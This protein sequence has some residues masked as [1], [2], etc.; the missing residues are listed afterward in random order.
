MD[1]PRNADLAA[2]GETWTERTA[3]GRTTAIVASKLQPPP[4]PNLYRERPRLSARLDAALLDA[5]R[6]TLVSAAPGYGKSVAVAGWLASRKLA[7]AWLGLERQESDLARFVRYLVAAL[8][9]VRPAAGSG[10]LDLIA[11]GANPGVEEL[12]AAILQ[13]ISTSDEPFVLVLDDY[14]AIDSE[15]VHG[16]VGFLIGHWPPFVHTI[17]ITRRDPPLPLARLRAHAR[18]LELGAVDLRYTT[19]EAAL[20]VTDSMA[21]K[22]DAARLAALVERT[23]GWIAALHLS[24]VSLDERPL[25]ARFDT[26]SGTRAELFDYLADEVMTGLTAELREFLIRTS[27]ADRLTPELCD[28]LTGRHDGASLLARATRSNLLLTPADAAGESFR[29]HPLFADYLRSHLTELERREL[30]DRMADYLERHGQPEAAI[31]HALAAHSTERAI[32][33]LELQAR[34]TFEA[35]ELTTLLTW[36]DALPPERVTAS[37]ELASLRAW[38]LMFMGRLA[39]AIGE[40]QDHVSTADTVAGGP[41]EGRL[42]AL[43]SLVAAVAG[44]APVAPG[45]SALE[46]GHRALAL[47]DGDDFF[48][49][50]TL[51]SLGMATWTGGDPRAGFELWREA[52]AAAIRSGQ[53][54]AVL[55]ATAALAG[56]LNDLGRRQE[57]EALCRRTL[58]DFADHR[59]RPRPIAWLVRMSLGLVLYEANH[60]EEARFELERGFEAAS[61]YGF[62]GAMVVWAVEYVALVRQATGEPGAALQ[63]I[64]GTA[65]GARSAG[66]ALPSQTGEIEARIRLMQGD[67]VAAARW[68]DHAVLDVPAGSPMVGQMRADQ[69]VAIARVRLAQNRPGEALAL[70]EPAA[71]RAEGLG[72]LADLV[73]ILVLEARAHQALGDRPA[74]TGALARAVSIAAAGDYIRR[75]VD[76]GDQLTPL[77]AAARPASPDFVDRLHVAFAAAGRPAE[78]HREVLSE[79]VLDALTSRELEVLR[80]MA[81]GASDAEVAASLYISLATAKW[82]AANVRS[83]L[84]ASSRTRAIVRAKELG[85][86]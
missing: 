52:Y 34:P 3:T 1:A 18:L 71:A 37:P 25:D 84:E 11:T 44:P 72:L 17:V 49:A 41:A 28:E 62:G 85:L 27:L 64:A 75:I 80:L 70:L 5:T 69:E 57:A 82:H 23:E 59:G 7:T 74:A 6:L 47:L 51:Q 68:A 77:L 31:E 24:A 8:R 20:Y 45:S 16:L 19:D 56:G 60:L 79:R 73:S 36:L 32:R 61:A 38:S 29:Y 26:F 13:E 39:D 50:I 65:K 76:E 67:V 48:K 54:M 15:P 14:H 78:A 40:V 10:S 35:A 21:V 53:P 81:G 9:S 43:H 22:V 83:K 63:G 55:L 66:I 58:V 86:I 42:L 33:L 46:L 4:L 2:S 12:G 30:H